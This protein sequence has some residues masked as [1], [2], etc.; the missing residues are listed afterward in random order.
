MKNIVVCVDEAPVLIIEADNWTL[1]IQKFI[2]NISEEEYTCLHLE[3]VLNSY[4][5]EL[6]FKDIEQVWLTIPHDGAM[7][8]FHEV[9]CV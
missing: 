6:A 2:A 5:L 1:F 8:T 9:P 3:D 4:R 7:I